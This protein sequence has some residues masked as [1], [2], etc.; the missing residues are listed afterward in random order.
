MS[1]RERWSRTV[2]SA[3]LTRGILLLLA[4]LVG[5]WPIAGLL[6]LSFADPFLT[7]TGLLAGCGGAV[8]QVMARMSRP[9]RAPSIRRWAAALGGF[10]LLAVLVGDGMAVAAQWTPLAFNPLRGLPPTSGGGLLVTAPLVAAGLGQLIQGTRT[11]MGPARQVRM[12]ALIVVAVLVF[13]LGVEDLHFR[14]LFHQLLAAGFVAGAAAALWPTPR[15]VLGEA[16]PAPLTTTRTEVILQAPALTA[17]GVRRVGR[18][19]LIAVAAGLALSVSTIVMAYAAAAAGPHG[20]VVAQTLL[21]VVG[22]GFSVLAVI[23]TDSVTHILARLGRH[24]TLALT[25]TQTVVTRRHLGRTTRTSFDAADRRLIVHPHPNGSLL[26]IGDASWI[27]LDLEP[28]ALEARLQPVRKALVFDTRADVAEA[29]TAL[30]RTAPQR[31]GAVPEPLLRTPAE[32]GHHAL[33]CGVQALVI[34]LLLYVGQRS[35]SLVVLLFAAP[36]MAALFRT[37]HQL[38]AKRPQ[39]QVPAQDDATPAEAGV[40]DTEVG[41]E[42]TA[43]AV[44]GRRQQAQQAA[45]AGPPAGR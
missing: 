27:L 32:R 28:E 8:L 9:A 34:A 25:P 19:L 17:S 14:H 40:E 44:S 39:V 23:L 41:G 35:G 10:G 12:P 45:G 38:H 37:S 16:R 4:G 36:W 6:G 20:P 15:A 22:V 42:A 13:Q 11:R 5:W 33:L 31:R 26:H 24:T 18:R 1:P 29:H 21:A 30:G 7:T 43:E 3:V 2:Q